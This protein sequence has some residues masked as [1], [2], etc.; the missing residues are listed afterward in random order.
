VRGTRGI[1]QIESA[2]HGAHVAVATQHR[3]GHR[4]IPRAD[5]LRQCVV[6]AT[7]SH[8][9]AQ[10]TRQERPWREALAE[11]GEQQRLVVQGPA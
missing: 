9:G 1:E 2:F 5:P 3:E 6:A 11:F 4:R 8:P 7:G 10:R